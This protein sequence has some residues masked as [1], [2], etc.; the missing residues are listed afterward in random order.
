MRSV[1]VVRINVVLAPKSCNFPEVAVVVEHFFPVSNFLDTSTRGTE[2][3]SL[4]LLCAWD[5]YTCSVVKPLMRP[6]LSYSGFR[7]NMKSHYPESMNDICSPSPAWSRHPSRC[8]VLWKGCAAQSENQS[9]EKKVAL[10]GPGRGQMELSSV[11]APFYTFV[12]K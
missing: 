9:S 4:C 7:R 8:S 1:P 5:L 6:L 12:L 11:L 10:P 2:M 3:A